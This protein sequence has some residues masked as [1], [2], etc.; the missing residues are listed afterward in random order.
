MFALSDLALPIVQAP[1]A[2]GPSTPALAVAVSEAGGLGL[3]AAG[4][5]SAAAVRDD[6]R[7]VRAATDR[8]FGVNL[9][10][11]APAPAAP[12]PLDGYLSEIEPEAR[13]LGVAVGDPR[14]DDDDWSAKLEV[15]IA[16]RVSVVSFTFGCPEAAT[17]TA[18]HEA[19]I[20]AWVTVTSVEEA[21][22][23]A[24]AGADALVVQG[25]EAG[26]HRGGF[27]DDDDSAA[28]IGLIAL[29]RLVAHAVARP[30]VATGGI[31][32]GAAVAAVLCAGASAA[33]VG[34]ALMLADEAATTPAQR[35]LLAEPGPTALTRAFTGRRPG[36]WST[37]SCASTTRRRRRPTRTST[38]RRA[39]CAR[40]PASAET[41]TRST[42]GPVRRTSSPRPGRRARSWPRWPPRPGGASRTCGAGWG[43][44]GG[45]GASG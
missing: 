37:A 4:Y 29:L 36:A 20:A 15:V 28:G 13:R 3:L 7:S 10:V 31:A 40:R 1:M 19:G 5:K 24:G 32:D 18:L 22:E 41:P 30:L 14:H 17:L 38:T 45:V 35:E 42:C 39:A 43:E 2:G 23:A 33:Q 27:R 16:E 21:L 12:P 8:A 34:T 44:E 6:I 25:V 11:P 26:G 9:F